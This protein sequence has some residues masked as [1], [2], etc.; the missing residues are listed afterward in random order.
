MVFLSISIYVNNF[1][2]WRDH[3]NLKFNIQFISSS[4]HV[5]F[6]FLLN[7]SGFLIRKLMLL[8]PEI[9][10]IIQNSIRKRIPPKVSV[11]RKIIIILQISDWIWLG[12]IEAKLAN[13]LIIV[14]YADGSS[15]KLHSLLWTCWFKQFLIK[16]CC[17]LKDYNKKPCCQCG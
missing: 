6:L 13:A 3:M 7:G 15:S 8:S 10:A 2:S 12:G 14:T 17:W 16:E 5:F 11:H 1:S 4:S 9:T